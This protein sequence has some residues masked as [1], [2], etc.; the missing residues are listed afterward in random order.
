MS[1]AERSQ[2]SSSAAQVRMEMPMV[3]SSSSPFTR[4]SRVAR[5]EASASC[6]GV[7]SISS[8]TYMVWLWS[9]MYSVLCALRSV[10]ID[11]TRSIAF[12]GSQGRTST[13]M[14]CV[15]GS[16][17]SA[18]SMFVRQVLPHELTYSAW[19]WQFPHEMCRGS[20]RVTSGGAT[21]SRV[22]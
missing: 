8:V 12:A 17:A 6:S 4:S 15:T 13:V 18:E 19:P 5:T 16:S 22:V 7:G 11:S 10:L 3:K 14:T 21:R 1:F 2:P 9:R 20:G